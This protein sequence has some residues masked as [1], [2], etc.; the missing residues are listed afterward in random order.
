MITESQLKDRIAA[1]QERMAEAGGKIQESVE[2]ESDAATVEVQ[3]EVI[4]QETVT[5]GDVDMWEGKTSFSQEPSVARIIQ[6]SR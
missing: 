4:E 5:A 6:L 2:Q 1:L 3:D